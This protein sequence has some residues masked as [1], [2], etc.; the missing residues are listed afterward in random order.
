MKWSEKLQAIRDDL[1]WMATECTKGD[2][3]EAAHAAL[4]VTIAVCD[5]GNKLEEYGLHDAEWDRP[6]TKESQS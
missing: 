5:L 4:G 1:K 2:D 6:V 3:L